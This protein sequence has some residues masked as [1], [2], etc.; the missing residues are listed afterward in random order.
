MVAARTALVRIGLSLLCTASLAVVCQG[1]DEPASLEVSPQQL[2]L[3]L[4][5]SKALSSK[6][7]GREGVVQWALDGLGVLMRAEWDVERHLRSGRLVQVLPQWLTPEADVY[8]VYPQR[9]QHSTRVRAFVDFLAA[10]FGR[11]RPAA[12]PTPARS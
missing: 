7:K 11:L 6:L 9:H 8:A 1:K 10:S 12:A 2:K 3:K 4:G 5:E